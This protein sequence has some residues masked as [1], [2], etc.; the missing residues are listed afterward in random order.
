MSL[1]TQRQ[2]ATD[3]A[4]AQALSYP[5]S[6]VVGATDIGKMALFFGALGMRPRPMGSIG[7]DVASALYGLDHPVRQVEMITAGSD[8]TVRI[9]ETPHQALPFTPLTGGP[10]GLDFFSNDVDTTMALVTAAGGHN[11]TEFVNFGLE[12]S[13]HPEAATTPT[14]CENL[15]QG[16]DELG[17]YITDVTRTDNP[18][19]SLLDRDP[20]LMT[21]ELIEI[22]W[23]VADLERERNFWEQEVGVD[24]VFECYA[25][26]EG[27]VKLMRHPHPTLLRCINV[28]DDEAH[29]RIE[30]MSYPDETI[31]T[32]PNWP[33]RGGLFASLFWVDDIAASMA[34]L[35]SAEF[36][37][38]VT[39]TDPNDGPVTAVSAA[40]PTGVRFEIR[41]RRTGD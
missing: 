33:L 23:V 31:S 7:T 14:S 25:E 13:M 4:S 29:T 12:P 38:V 10:Y 21:S 30:F 20:E 26:N 19:P 35:P 2:T 15:L 1:T 34:R 32:P 36:G 18:R 8:R 6:A 22:C 39:F 17:M 5:T 40:S 41:S 24:V 11:A 27:M 28:S 16:P 9:V 37:T 3:K